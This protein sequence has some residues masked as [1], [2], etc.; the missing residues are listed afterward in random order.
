MSKKVNFNNFASEVMK[1]TKDYAQ[2]V[3]DESSKVVM[4]TAFEAE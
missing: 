3:E 2:E 1:I 4:E